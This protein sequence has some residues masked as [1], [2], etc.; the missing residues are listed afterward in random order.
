MI[1][2]NAE[3]VDR[4]AVRMQQATTNA[5]KQRTEIRESGRLLLTKRNAQ[6]LAATKTTQVAKTISRT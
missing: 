4:P 6:R 1:A 3:I 2:V 5:V